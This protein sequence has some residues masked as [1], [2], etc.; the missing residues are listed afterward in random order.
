MDSYQYFYLYAT[1]FSIN[2]IINLSGQIATIKVYD[3]IFGIHSLSKCCVKFISFIF[4]YIKKQI[5]EIIRFVTSWHLLL[6]GNETSFEI[7]ISTFLFKFHKILRRNCHMC[8]LCTNC[9]FSCPQSGMPWKIRLR[10]RIMALPWPFPKW[11]A[12]TSIKLC[13]DYYTPFHLIL[14]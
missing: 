11:D 13:N 14:D 6:K 4:V 2:N 3:L 12:L 9:L 5:N 7:G 10:T 8:F 1:T